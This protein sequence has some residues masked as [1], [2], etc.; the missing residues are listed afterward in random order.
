MFQKNNFP[1]FMP[2]DSS[3]SPAATYNANILRKAKEFIAAKK[4]QS[5]SVLIIFLSFFLTS[6]GYLAWLRCLLSLMPEGTPELLAM[7]L[8]YFFQSLGLALFAYISLKEP[9]KATK[10]SFYFCL[11]TYISCAILSILISSR[12][13]MVLFGA[14]T[15]IIC[16]TIAGFYLYLLGNASPSQQARI[17]GIGYAIATIASWLFSLIEQVLPQSPI[18]PICLMVVLT[19]ML[20]FS[21]RCQQLTSYDSTTRPDIATIKNELIIAS[22]IVFLSSI[23]NHI[24]FSFPSS[25][26]KNGINLELLRL[27]YALGLL[28]AG[29]V[30]DRNRKHGAI[31]AF[32][33]LIL[34][35]VN[36]SLKNETV[37]ASA[38]W[39]LGY[40]SSGFFSVYRI[41]LFMDIA[42]K[43]NA[44][45]LVV[46]GL[47][48]GRL[49]ES[50]GATLCYVLSN[51]VIILICLAAILYAITTSFFFRLYQ[52]QFTP[53]EEPH[54]DEENRFEKFTEQYELSPR[55]KEILTLLLE[56]ETTPSIAEKLFVTE[57]TVKFHI[58]NLLHKTH[59]K[60]RKELSALFH[61]QP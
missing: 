20:C 2:V 28:I 44:P 12:L 1:L 22:V 38:L 56:K 24:G 30:N 27:F 47:L 45:Y 14:I 59:C 43:Y 26:I 9:S 57:S 41:I 60:N 32:G 55:E 4:Q 17:F 35:F 33:A 54:K 36:L 42:R 50:L 8:G 7:G 52:T 40:L 49:G 23:V 39:S 6:T 19:I 13:L 18:F 10:K 46:F 15:N 29:H 34:P 11:L 51:N 21:I 31:L 5:Q 16:G 25:D 3:D 53:V 61:S 37:N 48:F 58:H